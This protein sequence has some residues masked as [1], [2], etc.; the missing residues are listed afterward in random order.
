M[1]LPSWLLQAGI[2]IGVIALFLLTFLL[3]KRTKTP[4]GVELPDKC[5][6][7]DSPSCMIKT[8]EISKIKTELKQQLEK[9]CS[10][11][12]ENSNEKK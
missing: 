8:S 1:I 9:N 6:V 2:I 11:E 5:Q 10:N 4:K 12:E 3:H 7:C